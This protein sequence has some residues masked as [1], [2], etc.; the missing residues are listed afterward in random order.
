MQNQSD[1]GKHLEYYLTVILGQWETSTAPRGD[2]HTISTAR[3]P[4][5]A[6][7]GPRSTRA[8]SITNPRTSASTPPTAMPTIRNGKSSS[9]IMGYSTSA[10][11]AMGQQSIRRIHHR[12]KAAIGLPPC[13]PYY[14][15]S[16]RRASSLPPRRGRRGISG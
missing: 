14:I 6:R 9:Q 10:S 13:L 5:Y 15:R 2:F 4:A 8:G 1:V 12:K 16:A 3:L 11:S 7:L